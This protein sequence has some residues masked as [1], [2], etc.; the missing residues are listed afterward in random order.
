MGTIDTWVSFLDLAY[1]PVPWRRSTPVQMLASGSRLWMDQV[2]RRTGLPFTGGADVSAARFTVRPR[3]HDESLCRTIRPDPV[4]PRLV[5]VHMR[6]GAALRAPPG[7]DLEAE[8]PG[9]ETQ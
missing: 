8:Q 7:F 3:R 2:R 9:D 6:R 4:I 1:G 5:Q